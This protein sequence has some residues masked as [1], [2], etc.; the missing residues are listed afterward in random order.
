[1]IKI[2]SKNY[3]TEVL[4][5]PARIQYIAPTH[6]GSIIH[7]DSGNVLPCTET[8]EQVEEKFFSSKQKNALLVD[9]EELKSNLADRASGEKIWPDEFPDDFPRYKNGTIIKNSK[10]YIEYIKDKLDVW[11]LWEKNGEN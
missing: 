4:V 7:F 2:H 6:D 10:R 9:H 8:L 11:K 3:N 1:M 5:N